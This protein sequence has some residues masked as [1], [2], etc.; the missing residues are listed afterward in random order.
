[1]FH[2][3]RLK[4]TGWYLLIIMLISMFFSI[5]IYQILTQ[6]FEHGL[7]RITY[8]HIDIFDANGNPIHPPLVEPGYIDAAEARIRWTL[9]YINLAILGISGIAGYFLAGRTLQPIQ[10]MVDEQHRFVTDASHELRTPLTS[11]RSEIEVYLRGKE[12]NL[13][14]AD[15]LLKSNLE[16]V[17]NLQILSDNLIQLAQYKKTNTLDNFSHV[18]L[19]E[20]ILSAQKKVVSLAKK[21]QIALKTEIKDVIINGDKQNLVELF[22]I[23]LDNAIKYSPKK[24][25]IA[26]SSQSTDHHVVI[27]V[28]DEGMGIAKED[29]PY[30]F[31]RFYRADASR[32]KQSVLGYGLGLSIAKKI[33]NSH[34]GSIQ[35]KS[36]SGKGTTFTVQLP[37]ITNK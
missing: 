23:L 8:R 21:K 11:L 27:A 6:E 18:S 15:I 10:E 20:I 2:S 17:N 5:A 33:V 37:Y 3:A 4:L 12:H 26:V 28:S 24:T 22:V 13:K 30:I 25:T 1:M 32:T 9:V 29:L 31:D 14:E 16:E 34:N 36:N 7:Q 19:S 35:V